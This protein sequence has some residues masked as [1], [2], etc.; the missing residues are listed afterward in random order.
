[1]KQV[2][3]YNKLKAA[4]RSESQNINSSTYIAVFTVNKTTQ[5]MCNCQ[6]KYDNYIYR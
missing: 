5:D 1:M 4:S 6:K 2:K 3:E